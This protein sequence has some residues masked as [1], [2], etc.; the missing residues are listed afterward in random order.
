MDEPQLEHGGVERSCARDVIDLLRLPEQLA[1]LAPV[2]ARE[3]RAH[4]LAQVRGLADVEGTASCIA[5]QVD[6]GPPGQSIGEAELGR[7]RMAV[8]AGEREQVVEPEHAVGSSP[9][10]QEVEEVGRGAA[11]RRG[12]GATVGGRAGSCLRGST[13][14]SWAP[15]RARD[16]GRARTCRPIG[17][18]SAPT[19]KRAAPRRGSR[20]RSARCGRRSPCPS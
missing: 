6:P 8:D 16:A 15:R 11:R 4:A 19:R 20:D 13:A 3:V 12:L 7:L 5:E 1:D 14:G 10:E 17:A 9:L 2:V 18:S